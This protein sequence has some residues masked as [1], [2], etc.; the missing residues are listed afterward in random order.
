MQSVHT[1]LLHTKT[2]LIPMFTEYLCKCL[3]LGFCSPSLIRLPFPFPTLSACRADYFAGPLLRSSQSILP[4]SR[5]C[6]GRT[7]RGHEV[8]RDK[9]T[10][11][12]SLTRSLNTQ[13]PLRVDSHTALRDIVEDL[14]RDGWGRHTFLV[15]GLVWWI[16]IPVALYLNAIAAFA[17]LSP[18][19]LAP[20]QHWCK[21]VC[22][23]AEA[24]RSAQ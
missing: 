3:G 24:H 18:A 23:K 4:R 14:K 1:P 6:L 12:L 17:F 2:N 15:P 8:E 9:S 13:Q 5:Q 7:R 11:S 10:L 20:V 16:S 19:F 21:S 22:V